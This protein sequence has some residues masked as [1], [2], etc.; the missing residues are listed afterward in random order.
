[1]VN[2]IHTAKTHEP[3]NTTRKNK[4]K[5]LIENHPNK[6]SFQQDLSQ[7]QKINK[8][9]KE[10]QDLIADMINTEI[11]ELCEN[12]SKQIFAEC[13]TFWE[14]SFVLQL[15]KTFLNLRGVQ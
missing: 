5:R 7:T 12:S 8:F 11:F 9:C 1:M 6:E 2:K 4:V 14:S 10:S 13:N 3:Q 15:W